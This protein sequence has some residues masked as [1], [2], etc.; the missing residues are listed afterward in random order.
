MGDIITYPYNRLSTDRTIQLVD[1]KFNDENFKQL[2]H[3]SSYKEIYWTKYDKS[4]FFLN[5]F[6]NP[7]FYLRR[8]FKKIVIKK[9]MKFTHNTQGT[10]VIS[11][12]NN[13]ENVAILQDLKS[14]ELD[15]TRIFIIRDEEKAE[16][17]F[18]E[19]SNTVH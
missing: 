14:S 19:L 1:N 9:K 12:I 17:K 10:F 13:L 2:C 6:Y 16:K 5:Q 7:D 3:S 8:E 11:G 18:N 4:K 15:S